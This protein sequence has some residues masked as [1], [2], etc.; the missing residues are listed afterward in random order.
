MDI[1][2]MV[3]A[4]ASGQRETRSSYHLTLGKAIDVLSKVD[5]SLKVQF[6]FDKTSGPGSPDSY[7][8][9]YAD[10]SFEIGEVSTVKK[11]L[12]ELNDSIDKTFVGYKGGEFVMGEDTPLWCADY[13]ETGRAIIALAFDESVVIQTKVVDL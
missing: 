7:R 4:I 12:N 11:F 8:G 3:N 2:A 5:G 6:D 9:Y 10:L 1:Q 13:G